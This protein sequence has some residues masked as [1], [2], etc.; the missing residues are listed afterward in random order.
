VCCVRC[1]YLLDDVALVAAENASQTYETFL[2]LLKVLLPKLKGTREKPVLL[3]VDGHISRLQEETIKLCGKHNVYCV[4]LPSHTSHKLQVCFRFVSNTSENSKYQV[5]DAAINSKIDSTYKKKYTAL[6][7]AKRHN[8]RLRLEYTDHITLLRE[9]IAHLKGKKDVITGSWKRVGLPFG[10]IDLE[11]FHETK[12]YDDG[13]IYRE[14]LPKVTNSF[15]K[16]AVSLANIA[17]PWRDRLE[18]FEERNLALEAMA[19]SERELRI[20][21]YF[22]MVKSETAGRAVLT[23]IFYGEFNG[24]ATSSVD[25][26]KDVHHE[27]EIDFVDVDEDGS[28][29]ELDGNEVD[30]EQ[31]DPEGLLLTRSGRAVSTAMGQNLFGKIISQIL[32]E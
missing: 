25:L 18:Y 24:M 16:S 23:R 6:L 17:R 12:F 31:A 32:K 9:T 26:D 20:S 21:Y 29:D 5:G 2:G 22:G 15:L 14:N 8:K 27:L 28:E 3:I 13:E 19:F 7:A 1:G 11:K 30:N 10:A 4:I